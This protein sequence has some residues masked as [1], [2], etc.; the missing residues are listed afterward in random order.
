MKHNLIY[1]AHIAMHKHVLAGNDHAKY[2]TH[3]EAL[4]RDGISLRC[5]RDTLASLL[6]NTSSIAPRQPKQLEVN[7]VLPQNDYIVQCQCEVYSLRRI[8]KDC[9]QLDMK[10]H[11]LSTEQDQAIDNYIE[12]QLHNPEQFKQDQR[13]EQ[14]A[15]KQSAIKIDRT[16]LQWS[17]LSK[18]LKQESQEV[19]AA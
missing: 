5:D 8:S 12:A 15:R 9:F 2:N 4:A 11:N 18:F 7:F 19:Q 6:P 13:V 1:H 3:L 17:D 14:Q 10:F 16:K